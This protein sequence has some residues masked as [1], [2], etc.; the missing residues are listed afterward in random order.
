[1]YISIDRP[2][3]QDLGTT[4]NTKTLWK[5]SKHLFGFT[6]IPFSGIHEVPCYEGCP[7][8]LSP[9]LLNTSNPCSYVR[10]YNVLL[11]GCHKDPR[12]KERAVPELMLSRTLNRT[13]CV[14]TAVF[15]LKLSRMCIKPLERSHSRSIS[16]RRSVSIRI[17]HFANLHSIYL[18]R[19]LTL[20][21]FTLHFT[22][23]TTLLLLPWEVPLALDLLKSNLPHPPAAASLRT[24]MCLRL[25]GR[26]LQDVRLTFEVL[27]RSITSDTPSKVSQ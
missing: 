7:S 14:F 10:F 17:I 22:R 21:L 13:P 11:A 3:F 24:S 16:S 15:D 19:C 2:L 26:M 9:C 18:L 20:T 8:L 25:K 27:F 23:H 12:Y 5:T 4:N 6:K 1:M